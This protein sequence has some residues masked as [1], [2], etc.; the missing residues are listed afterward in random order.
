MGL[1]RLMYLREEKDV[2]EF[3]R[4]PIARTLK[5]ELM[6]S[7]IR[8]VVRLAVCAASLTGALRVAHARPAPETVSLT[9]VAGESSAIMRQAA[10]RFMKAN[11][12]VRVEVRRQSGLLAPIAFC[13]GKADVMAA[14][15]P[16]DILQH[17]YLKDGRRVW[18]SLGEV[19]EKGQLEGH[20]IAYR[21]L[22]LIVN[23]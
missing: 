3:V 20:V 5:R 15:G 11:P 13:A 16:G 18:G 6:S 9:V 8:A 1:D 17:R 7:R 19:F 10:E 14:T 12:G 22:V 23:P 21:T 2:C 4:F